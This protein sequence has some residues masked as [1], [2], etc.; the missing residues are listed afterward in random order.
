MRSR[1][2]GCKCPYGQ[3]VVS[4]VFIFVTAFE[5]QQKP[6]GR[7]G[8]IVETPHNVPAVVDPVPSGVWLE[9]KVA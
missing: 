7:A 4:L 5:L 1:G 2:S 8:R 3:I 9:L 6:A